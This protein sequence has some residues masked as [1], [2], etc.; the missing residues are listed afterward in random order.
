M[1][2]FVL[3]PFTLQRSN[4]VPILWHYCIFTS[5]RHVI[6][7]LSSRGHLNIKTPSYR[8]LILHSKDKTISWPSSL[9]N[10]NPISGK[11]VNYIETAPW[12]RRKSIKSLIANG[13]G[14]FIETFSSIGWTTCNSCSRKVGYKCIWMAPRGRLNIT[15][16]SNQYRDPHVKDKTVSWPSYI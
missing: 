3:C 15:M 7:A 16:S 2:Y 11:T 13:R 10:G 6:W 1:W 4:R 8:Y 9:Y 12:M 5:R 14:A